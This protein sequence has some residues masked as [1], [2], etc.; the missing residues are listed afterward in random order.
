VLVP[1]AGKADGINAVRLTLP[2]CLFHPRTED[3]GMSALEQYRREWDDDKKC[4]KASELHDWSSHLADAFRYLALSWRTIP[5]H[6]DASIPTPK[7]GQTML[8]PAPEDMAPPGRRI[9]LKVFVDFSYLSCW[10]ALS[11]VRIRL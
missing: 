5:V 1:L 9:A 6:L 2:R 4:F 7:A 3:V 10:F 8:P 11:G